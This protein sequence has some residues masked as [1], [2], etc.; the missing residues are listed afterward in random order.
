MAKFYGRS[1]TMLL[2]TDGDR[3]AIVDSVFGTVAATGALD[4]L[5]NY[6]TW[7]AGEFSETDEQTAEAAFSTMNTTVAPSTGRVYTVPRGAQVTA[8]RALKNMERHERGGTDVSRHTA[9]LLASGGKIDFEKLRHIS[10]Y[11]SRHSD[12]RFSDRFDPREDGTP[13]AEHITWDMWGGDAA[14][15]WTESIIN[16]EAQKAMT[17]DAV[18]VPA[19]VDNGGDPFQDAFELDP[20]AGPEFLARVRMDGS[21][22]DRLYKIDLDGE[23]YVWDDNHWDNLGTIRGDIYSF[24]SQLDDKEDSDVAKTHIVID[25]SSAVVIGA[26]LNSEP[27]SCVSIEDIDGDEA[28]LVKGGM[29]G[30]EWGL[31]DDALTAA[32]ELDAANAEYSPQERSK[33]ASSQTRDANGRFAS[34]GQRVM[35]AGDPNQ[36]GTITQVDAANGNVN[37]QLEK[38]GAVTVPAKSVGA[39]VEVPV[40]APVH[41]V[42]IP[43]V[44]LSGI[45][46]EPRVPVNN[47]TAKI[48]GTLPAMTSK[49]IHDVLYNYPAW[50]K[51]QR[52]NFTPNNR[53]VDNGQI[54]TYTGGNATGLPTAESIEKATGVKT[55]LDAYDNPL[56]ADWLRKMNRAGTHSNSIWYQPVFSTDESLTAGM[57]PVDG[58]PQTPDNSDV[59]PIY[60]AVVTQD[61]PTAVTKLIAV[62]PASST[63]NS[64]MV[65]KRQDGL[66]E[67]DE[68]TM[69]DLQ[70]ATPPPVVPLTTDALEDCLSQVDDKQDETNEQIAEEEDPTAQDVVVDGGRVTGTQAA[71]EAATPAPVAAAAMSMDETLMLLWGPREDLMQH[72]L[73]AA[74]GADRN[75]GGAEKLR[76][77]WTHGAGAAKIGWG[78]PGDWTRCVRHLGKYMGTRAKGYCALRHKETTGMWTGDK[79]NRA[80]SSRFEGTFSTDEIVTEDRFNERVTLEARAEIARQR[81][82]ALVAAAPQMVF[83]IDQPLPENLPV[84]EGHGSPF[85][86]PTLVPL[87]I[88]S[89]DGRS[90]AEDAELELRNLPITLLWQIQT[91]SAHD[92]SVIVGRIDSAEITSEGIKNARGVFDTGVF[93]REA[94]RL[95][96]ER[97]LRGVSVDMDNFEAQEIPHEFS[98]EDL[99]KLVN[100]KV[101]VTKTRAMAATLV[102]KPAF[103]ECEIFLVEEPT[104]EEED[105]MLHDMEDGYYTEE[106]DPIEAAALVAAGY[107]ASHIPVAPPAEWFDAPKLDKLTPITV[108]DDGR[109]FGHIASWSQDHIGYANTKTN[110]P[111]SRS[112]YAYFHTGVL[113]TEQGSDVEVGQLTLAGG[114]AD[115]AFSARAAAKHYDD[116]ASAIADVRAG[117]DAYGIYVS[118]ALRPGVTPEQIRVFRASAPS[119]DWR[120]INRTLELVAVCQVNVPGFPVA[121]TLVA[122]GQQMALVAAGAA[123]V[124][125]LQ[126]D[127]LQEM[128]ARLE[129]LEQFS[130]TELSAKVDPIRE[131]FAAV[132]A[133]RQAELA[134]QAD[135]VR[136]RFASFATKSEDRAKKEAVEKIARQVA[137]GTPADVDS[138][139]SQGTETPNAPEEG[140]S[141][142]KFT[143]ETQ[144]RDDDGKFRL[145]LARLRDNVGVEGNQEILQKIAALEGIHQGDY[146]AASVAYA[147]LSS[148]LSKID[149]GALPDGTRGTLRRV[150]VDLAKAVANLPLPF[151][152]QAQKVRFSDLPPV[153]RTMTEQLVQKVKDKYGAEAPEKLEDITRFMSGGD[154]FA[155]K[156]VSSQLNHLVHLL[157]A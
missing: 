140:G 28:A 3:G 157:T 101:E 9:A 125:R 92:G 13:S 70:S 39:P 134:V 77:Y 22:I 113:R 16:R 4:L 117:E 110:A 14:Q 89:G 144:P 109:V 60:L 56:I 97:M 17:A 146:K 44:D 79:R 76:H 50:V 12:D 65:Y 137:P 103:Q 141:D 115:L 40:S 32:G 99:G 153:L 46:A 91:G 155:Q 81:V 107:V 53:P 94:E 123:A 21:G 37:V 88:E 85:I 108:T 34:E 52:D 100:T 58:D 47:P 59:Q 124:A 20:E 102:A 31:V 7:S 135:A 150:S 106:P 129:K 57:V 43:K 51:A 33:N 82:R 49:A 26:R 128:Q 104:P 61:D 63:S 95:V 127:P 130:V 78:T 122:G 48:P 69:G 30:T 139:T 74:G 2:F 114:H 151:D 75:R 45:L 83:P 98:E 136:A 25:P 118:G 149:S 156:D 80:M 71:P 27:F 138:K 84:P 24:D 90:V 41:P 62:V 64:P 15:K 18:V 67:R 23:V 96:R 126:S 66:W 38:G 133:A 55:T 42:A 132:K 72:A 68:R 111:R 19:T 152:D 10:R 148:S 119:G 116:T 145:I 112:N 154:F 143:P 54:P 142:P 86:I 5:K 73:T 36:V 147:D 6:G 131:K 35:V 87:G 8:A 29:G 121:R 120:P 93:G 105:E 1:G 11:F